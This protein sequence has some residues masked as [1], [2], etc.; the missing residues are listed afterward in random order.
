MTLPVQ[1][2]PQLG[3]PMVHLPVYAT[4]VRDTLAQT[5]P[6]GPAV[7][8][9]EHLAELD[10]ASP[11]LVFSLSA[12]DPAEEQRGPGQHSYVTFELLALT[13]RSQSE[14]GV[15]DLYTLVEQTMA[16]TYRQRWGLDGAVDPC[17]FVSAG[18]SQFGAN[19][20]NWYSWLTTWRQLVRLPVPAG[21]DGDMGLVI[22]PSAISELYL[23]IDPKI[24]IAHIADYRRLVPV[25]VP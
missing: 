6:A 16:A 18:Q 14:A 11:L 20:D 17:E 5:V 13:N 9:A 4:A 10:G 7:V 12:I 23:G 15:L 21:L 2:L 1:P 3:G 22:D 19:T 24:G 25:E 8:M